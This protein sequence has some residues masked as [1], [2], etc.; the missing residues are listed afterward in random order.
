MFHP[1]ELFVGL[2]YTR[3]KRRNHFISFIT[4][5]SMLGIALGVTALITVLSV[6]NGFERELQQRILGMASDVTISPFEGGLRD[7]ASLEKRVAGAPGVTGVAPY[8]QG[9]A[10]V[11]AGRAVSGVLLQG[12]VPAQQGQVSDVGSHMVSGHLSALKPG[13]FGIVLGRD[14]AAYLGVGPGDHVTVIT[15]DTT[16]TPAG[17]LPRFRRFTVVGVFSVGMYQY[18]RS[19]A[20]IDMQDASRLFRLNGVTGL[21]LKLQH[22]MAA[23]QVAASLSRQLGS[24]YWVSDWT[25]ENANFFHAVKTEKTVMFVILFLIVAVGV[26]N[27]VS[28]L[29]MVVTDK[30][31]DIAILRTLGLSPGRVMRIFMIQ[32]TIIGFIGVL[33]GILGGVMLSLNVETIVPAIEKLFHVQFLSP[34]VYYI[35]QLPSHLEWRDVLHIGVIAFVLSILATIYPAWRAARTQPAEAL[36]Y[37]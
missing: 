34:K 7:W 6:M 10:M 36:R 16:V 2:R 12:I 25:Q 5:I 17:I 32:G 33:I 4:L 11:T 22:V 3:A 30:Q 31:S 35:S 19:M 1:L 24:K 14:L 13:Q 9:E 26:F 21:R 20:F 28:T 18:D 8:V 23:P 15:P 37:D 29:V 27:I